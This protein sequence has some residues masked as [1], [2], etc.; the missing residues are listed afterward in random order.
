MSEQE[1]N[2]SQRLVIRPG[3]IE[4]QSELPWSKALRIAWQSIRVRIWR[5]LLVTSGIILA[6]AFLAYILCSGTIQHNIVETASADLIQNLRGSGVLAVKDE[7]A[8]IQT[9][10]MVGLALLVSFVGVLNAMTLSVTE[11]FR[12]IGTMKCL[13]ALDQLVVRLFLLESV[14]QGI[15]GTTV[16][17]AIGLTLALAE[18]FNTFGSTMWSSF[19]FTALAVRAAACLGAGTLLTV[20]SALYPAFIAARMEPIEAMR[21]EV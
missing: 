7:E 6:V 14:F 16:G 5:S 21:S 8:Q 15:V 2:G 9:R 13:G 12:E 11:R 20:I 10:W 19:P 4:R 1:R 3:E 17:I 18:G